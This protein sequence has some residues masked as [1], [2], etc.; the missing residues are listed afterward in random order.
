MRKRWLHVPGVCAASGV[1]PILGP[2][3][4]WSTDK[5]PPA[6]GILEAR[7]PIGQGKYLE[8]SASDRALGLLLS[9]LRVW[10]GSGLGAPSHHDTR[11]EEI[12][13]FRPS[14]RAGGAPGAGMADGVLASATFDDA[15]GQNGGMR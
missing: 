14:K 1:A 5:A 2:A 6:A 9:A 13:G 12:A 10:T 8:P 3:A 4:A 7:E 15:P 11:Q